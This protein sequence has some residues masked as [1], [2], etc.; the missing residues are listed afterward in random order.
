MFRVLTN[1][2]SA[3]WLPLHEKKSVL[4]STEAAISSPFSLR[5]ALK[6]CATVSPTSQC[7]KA[8]AATAPCCCPGEVALEFKALMSSLK[9]AATA[10]APQLDM[11][12]TFGTVEARAAGVSSCSPLEPSILSRGSCQAPSHNLDV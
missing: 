3:F 11:W 8:C 9:C 12:G 2:L 5:V 1:V 4:L 10:G 7:G 6:V